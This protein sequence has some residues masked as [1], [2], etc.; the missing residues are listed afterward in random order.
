MCVLV[1]GFFFGRLIGGNGGGGVEG[2]EGGIGKWKMGNGKDSPRRGGVMV[3]HYYC[4]A[5]EV[6]ISL[7]RR[8]D[9]SPLYLF[10]ISRC[11]PWSS[12]SASS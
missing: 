5:L 2:G 6:A 12:T 11:L 8:N 10:G 3:N 9:S 4:F 1:G 7:V